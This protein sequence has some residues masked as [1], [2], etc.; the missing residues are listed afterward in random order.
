MA[1][2]EITAVADYLHQIGAVHRSGAGVDEASFYPALSNLLSAIGATLNPK[3]ACVMQLRNRGEGQPDG[4]FF[5]AGQAAGQRPDRGAIEAKAVGADLDALAASGQV[6]RY[7]RGYGQV[8]ATN[9][10]AFTIVGTAPAGAPA[11]TRFETCVLAESAEELWQL[12]E[13]PEQAARRHG[14]RL[15]EFLKRGMQMRA[16]LGKPEDVAFFLAS[17]A[18]EALVRV[19][20]ASLEDLAGLRDALESALG[21]RFEGEKGEHFF[22]SS[23]IQALFYGLFSAWALE[24]QKNPTLPM[25][26]P[27]AG[28]CLAAAAASVAQAVL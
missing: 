9:L 1:S 13:A 19:E 20:T 5:T 2:A 14:A 3:V 26:I 22:R 15:A 6:E 27:L 11:A 17:Y 8:L 18:R 25:T 7:W 24:A 4:G 10:R 16:T 23:L 12:A 21:L 28:S